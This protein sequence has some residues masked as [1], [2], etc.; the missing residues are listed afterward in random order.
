MRYFFTI[1]VLFDTN[2]SLLGVI[3]MHSAGVGGGGFM[4]VYNRTMRKSQ[5]ID[6][7]EVAPA[8]AS[9]DMF[10]DKEDDSKYGE[11]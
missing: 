1:L 3:N 7:R 9:R 8:N 2:M 10:L 4:M 6:F 5:V 11:L